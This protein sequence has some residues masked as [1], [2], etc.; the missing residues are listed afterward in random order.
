MRRLLIVFILLIAFA[1]L[2][3]AVGVIFSRGSSSIG[4]DTVLTWRIDSP[5]VDYSE[6]PSLS[7]VFRRHPPLGL[8]RIHQVLT[9]A[10]DDDNV[11]GLAVYI[12]TAR[13][14]FAKAQELRSLLQSLTA[15]GK[16]VD[17]Y[18]ETAGEGTNGTMSYYL[19][20]AC[21]RITLSPLGE[22]N[23]VGLHSDSP[24]IRGTL[25][26]LRIEP[27]FLHVGDYK[28]A[29]E[30]YTETG[31][32][33][34][35]AEALGAVLDDLYDQ[36][37]DAIAASRELTTDEVRELMDQAPLDAE[38][39][40]EYGLLD[41]VTYPD[42]FEDRFAERLQDNPVTK[43]LDEYHSPP[44]SIGAHRVAVVFAQGTIVRGDNGT[45]PWSEQRYV[46]SESL[47]QILRPLAEDSGLAGVV[48]RVDSPGG[49]PVASDLILREMELLADQMPVV[50]SMSDV[51][52]SGGYYISSKAA[53][54][55]AEPATITGSIGVVGGKLATRRFQEELLGIS[56]DEINR[57]AN[58][59]FFSTLDPFSPAQQAQ[60][61]ALMTRIYD[62]FVEHVAQGR[63]MSRE[64][65]ESVAGGRIWTGRQALEIGLVDEVGG[66]GRAVEMVLEAGGHDPLEPTEL[67]FY[68]RPPSFFE[69]LSRGL[70]PLMRT[71]TPPFPLL[72]ILRTPQA[73][74]LPVELLELLRPS[75]EYV[76]P[77]H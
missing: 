45:D 64:E 69:M 42:V 24:F 9:T 15:A 54:I 41:E 7:L 73:L 34:A 2:V 26:K 43:P 25:D 53:K 46:G 58:A 71:G 29:A 52:A 74:E 62:I 20:T 5:L 32:S 59:D 50:V 70:S 21:E 30:F 49:S 76:V 60:Y 51:A 61:L 67:D 1:V 14:G 6:A 63:Q 3:A 18:L 19:A 22:W 39:A 68:P 27:Q 77:G 40:L 48:L 44:G 13:F 4:G 47:R 28:S 8:A 65:V 38:Q 11:K 31:H 37:V 55:I 16:F 36:I 56:H 33:E 35:A 72:P 10:R 12:Q 57:G 23:V 17:C 75:Y 66:L